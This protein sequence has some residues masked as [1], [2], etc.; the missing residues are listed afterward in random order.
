MAK[1]AGYRIVNGLKVKP[2]D[3]G[4]K[5]NFRKREKCVEKGR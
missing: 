5:D 3:Q 1:L 4:E 2:R